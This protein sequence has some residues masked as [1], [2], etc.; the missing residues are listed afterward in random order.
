MAETE[1]K[2]VAIVCMA[3]IAR[4]R[5]FEHVLRE[6]LNRRMG[7]KV[8]VLSFGVGNP[9]K[10]VAA[11]P[12]RKINRRLLG[13]DAERGLEGARIAEPLATKLFREALIR[14]GYSFPG[15]YGSSKIVTPETPKRQRDLASCDLILAVGEPEA[16]RVKALLPAEHHKKVRVLHEF[17]GEKEPLKDIGFGEDP[18]AAMD[19]LVHTSGEYARKAAVKID[20]LYRRRE[21]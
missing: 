19:A 12:P 17:V 4:S 6:H 5:T 7:K 3:N 8:E 20:S 18:K 14:G 9:Q 13:P 10:I 11:A 16:E 21:L 1:G 15:L 2:R